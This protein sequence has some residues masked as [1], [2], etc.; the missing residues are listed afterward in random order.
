[1]GQLSRPTQTL[2]HLTSEAHIQEAVFRQR[3]DPVEVDLGR[4]VDGQDGDV[5]RETC[6]PRLALDPP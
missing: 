1:V 4:R 3:L 6:A 5:D 2:L